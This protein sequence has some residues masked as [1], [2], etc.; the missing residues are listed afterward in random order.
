M[1]ETVENIGLPIKSLGYYGVISID[2][3]ACG[4]GFVVELKC[5][6]E[7]VRVLGRSSIWQTFAAFHTAR[8]YFHA[9]HG[10]RWAV[11]GQV[12]SKGPLPYLSER[13]HP[14]RLSVP[15]A[16]LLKVGR[17]ISGSRATHS[18]TVQNY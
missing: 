5:G 13:S 11:Q 9:L 17:V 2:Y 8:A 6:P 10:R 15:E 16:R 12:P 18:E 14:N 3:A 4:T 7:A 1:N